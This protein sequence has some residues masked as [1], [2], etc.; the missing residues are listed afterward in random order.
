MMLVAMAAIGFAA[1]AFATP[2]GHHGGSS[3]SAT[4]NVNVNNE[5]NYPQNVPDMVGPVPRGYVPVFSVYGQMDYQQ[6]GTVGAQLSIPL[7]R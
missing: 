5:T 2:Q 6:R 3:S 7:A 1:P 4:T